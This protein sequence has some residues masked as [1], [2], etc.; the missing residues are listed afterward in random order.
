[1]SDPAAPRRLSALDLAR[2]LAGRREALLAAAG[3]R[4]T[5][6]LGALLVLTAALAREYDGAY[7]ARQPEHV[8]LPFAASLVTSAALYLL[9]CAAQWIRKQPAPLISGY[10]RFLGLYW[11]TAPLAWFYAIPV[12]RFL[13]PDDAT[14]ANLRL[15]GFV[16]AWRVALMMRIVHLVYGLSPWQAAATVLW[17]GSSTTLVVLYFTPIPIFNV[18]GGI[19][20]TL[21]EQAIQSTALFV[22]FASVAVWVITSLALATG[23][24]FTAR[25]WAK[26]E[27]SPRW[28][29]SAWCV[30]FL[31][32]ALGLGFLPLT[33][34]EQQHRWE[35]EQLLR[36]SRVDDALRY[37]SKLERSDLPPHWD[38][39][40][41]IGYG[42]STPPL[43]DVLVRC[44][45]VE[46]A[47][48]VRGLYIAK[49]DTQLKGRYL[50]DA[51]RDDYGHLLDVL[52]RLP[53]T[54]ELV[55]AHP[56]E[57]CEF[58]G[59]LKY[60]DPS[61]VDRARQLVESAGVVVD[62]TEN[63]NARER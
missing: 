11:L 20:H 31:A 49:L 25:P 43:E 51:P 7:L 24:A 32:L 21:G 30:A 50:V 60:V 56:N 28:G 39:P 38:P 55:R 29:V 57:F 47:D 33:Q 3:S 15:L 14:V 18:M 35:A 19:H 58:V 4:W 62:R 6:P 17:F 61:E 41:R 8:L 16:A 52:E 34:P 2:F 5:L 23:L 9:V 48:W 27:S 12:E 53:E 36:A 45:D 44:L 54:P 40:P 22:G 1:M 59:A 63:P 46:A 13:S 37:L 10:P 42:E 26:L